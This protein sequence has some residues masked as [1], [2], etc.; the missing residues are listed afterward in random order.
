MSV[1]KNQVHVIL[2]SAALLLPG[3]IGTPIMTGE[4]QALLDD[5]ARLKGENEALR[6]RLGK[7]ERG[8]T[9]GRLEEATSAAA[10]ATTSIDEIRQEFSFIRGNFEEADHQ[11][12]QL[13]GEINS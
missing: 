7:L 4:Q 10:E 5:V 11:R 9:G 8:E 1:F 6:E 2:L 13:K 12:A 3:C